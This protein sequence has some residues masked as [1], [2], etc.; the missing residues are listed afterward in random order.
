M[1]YGEFGGTTNPF[2][3]LDNRSDV[4]QI[5]E[6][7]CIDRPQLYNLITDSQTLQTEENKVFTHEKS[8]MNNQPLRKVLHICFKLS[9]C[10]IS[11]C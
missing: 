10:V 3:M 4:A 9:S 2:T 8:T 11:L 5:P 6:V 1:R 7:L